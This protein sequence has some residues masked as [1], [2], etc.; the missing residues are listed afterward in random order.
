MRRL[1]RIVATAA[2]FGAVLAVVFVILPGGAGAKGFGPLAILPA[3]GVALY[4]SRRQ[5]HFF[6]A[7]VAAALPALLLLDGGM[8][9]SQV[10]WTL[11]FGVSAGLTTFG[12]A[13]L[14][15]RGEAEVAERER[16]HAALERTRERLLE[17]Q[18]SAH[19]GSWEWDVARDRFTCSDELLR[20]YGL[21]PGSAVASHVVLVDSVH[22]DDRLAVSVVLEA[23]VDRNES[24]H[25]EHRI[26]RGDGQVRWVYVTGRMIESDRRPAHIAGTAHDVTE[27]H[28]AQG[29]LERSNEELERYAYAIS[30]DLSEPIR[31]MS[32]FARLL[33]ERH[34]DE[35]DGDAKRFV[36]SIVTGADRMEELIHA[37]LSY[38]RSGSEELRAVDVDFDQIVR[39]VLEA[40]ESTITESHGLVTIEN[41]PTVHGDPV[42][43]RQLLQNLIANAFKFTSD[44][45][46]HVRISA[47]RVPGRW[48][49]HVQDNG[50]G[51]D[52]RQ[53]DR[54]WDIFQRLHDRSRPGTGVGLAICKRIVERHGGQ[55]SVAPAPGG[56]SVF[57]FTLPGARSMAASLHPPAHEE[58][59]TARRL[60]P[61]REAERLV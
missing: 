43:L 45:R 32:G 47:G 40:L 38:S 39:E 3:V 50:C 52:P 30:H 57:S 1:G 36:E 14:V 35:L 4:G 44:E 61:R 16:A 54:I 26:V 28:I 48:S 31:V 9:A 41:M 12:V 2:P 37:L 19:I 11:F 33:S 20:V 24:F 15:H 13:R 55:I 51:I 34:A 25:F 49:F 58:V 60:S 29:Q 10:R 53:A 46:P 22:Q 18:A 21:A 6:L 17:A 42:L 7:G 56:G 59:V 23:A 27:S 8:T 5:L